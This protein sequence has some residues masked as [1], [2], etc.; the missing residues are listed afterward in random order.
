MRVVLVHDFRQR[1][2]HLVRA[3]LVVCEFEPVLESSRVRCCLCVMLVDEGCCE[4]LDGW[5]GLVLVLRVMRPGGEFPV[6]STGCRQRVELQRLQRNSAQRGV[7]CGG[8]GHGGGGC[9]TERK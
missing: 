9:V 5:Q 1:H 6:Q 2:V 3:Q 7:A 4:R 8:G